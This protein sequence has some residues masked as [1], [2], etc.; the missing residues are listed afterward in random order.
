M[1]IYKLFFRHTEKN[2]NFLWSG[3]ACLL[4]L[5]YITFSWPPV[6]IFAFLLGPCLEPPRQE[7]GHRLLCWAA[8]SQ[9]WSL[10]LPS[11]GHMSCFVCSTSWVSVLMYNCT[12]L[13]WGFDNQ[14]QISEFIMYNCYLLG[15]SPFNFHNEIDTV[16]NSNLNIDLQTLCL[17]KKS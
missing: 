6:T 3:M 14:S 8:L 7:L 4:V 1:I 10:D 16:V 11:T 13:V 12:D 2:P 15:I 17:N 9:G 5:V